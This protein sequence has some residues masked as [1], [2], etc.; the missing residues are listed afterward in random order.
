MLR[1]TRGER[2]FVRSEPSMFRKTDLFVS[3]CL[4]VFLFFLFFFFFFLF[5]PIQDGT[6]LVRKSRGRNESQPFTLTVLFEKNLFRLKIRYLPSGDYAL[7]EKK[8]EEIVSIFIY[9]GKS[10]VLQYFGNIS[11]NLA[12]LNA[13]QGDEVDY[14]MPCL[15]DILPVLLVVFVTLA[16]GSFLEFIL[17]GLS[18]LAWSLRFLQTKQKF[19]NHLFTYCTVINYIFTFRKTNIV[20]CLHCAKDQLEFLK[21]NFP[22]YTTLYRF[23]SK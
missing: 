18:D 21:H 16:C 12:A 9:Y 15:L 4:N 23:V 17:L 6:F 13:F 11:H 22:N 20:D 7:G 19:F 2:V 1:S 5:F 14:E 3:S 10:K 8:D